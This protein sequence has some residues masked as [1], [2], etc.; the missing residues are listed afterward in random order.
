MTTYTPIE[1]RIIDNALTYWT[2]EKGDDGITCRIRVLDPEDTTAGDHIKYDP[3]C[4]W[5]YLGHAHSLRL[6]ESRLS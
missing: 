2:T 5:C 6:H 1:K 3:R 4:G